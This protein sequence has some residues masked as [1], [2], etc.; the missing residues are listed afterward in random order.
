MCPS[1]D[2]TEQK[3]AS[4]VCGGGQGRGCHAVA[5]FVGVCSLT[6][7]GMEGNIMVF[8]TCDGSEKVS[9]RRSASAEECLAKARKCNVNSHANKEMQIINKRVAL[10][11]RAAARRK[12]TRNCCRFL[13]ET[14]R[15]RALPPFSIQ[16]QPWRPL[17]APWQP[18]MGSRSNSQMSHC[19]RAESTQTV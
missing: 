18:P 11:V 19:R 6:P 8:A 16:R 7:D 3:L 12:H 9:L 4:D 1:P 15:E 5:S 17:A 13:A 14:G 10:C 2:C